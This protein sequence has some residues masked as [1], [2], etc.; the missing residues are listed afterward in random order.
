MSEGVASFELSV[1]PDAILVATVRRFVGDLCGR[2]LADA[3]VTSKVIV[4]THELLDNAIRYAS[5]GA[6]AP[7]EE[8]APSGVSSIRVELR[9]V[10]VEVSVVIVT[11]NRVND[12]RRRDLER[13]IDAMRSSDDRATF[14]KALLDRAAQGGEGAGLG[15]GRVHVEADFELSACFEADQIVVRAEGRFPLM[16]R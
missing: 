16:A 7:P 3:E 11:R 1:T 15:L 6:A 8:A 4:A 9:R 12:D 14:Y 2:V 10:G 13:V 5:R